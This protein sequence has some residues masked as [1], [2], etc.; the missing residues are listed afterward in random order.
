MAAVASA[1]SA[2]LPFVPVFSIA[3]PATLYLIAQVSRVG[4]CVLATV[5]LLKPHPL[6]PNSLQ[7]E[8]LSHDHN[9]Q[10]CK[11]ADHRLVSRAAGYEFRFWVTTKSSPPLPFSPD[12]DHRLEQHPNSSLYEI[13]FL[14]FKHEHSAGEDDDGAIPVGCSYCCI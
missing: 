12:P 13:C 14:K 3:L 5:Q 1:A 8:L 4:R 2:C 11:C 10:V 9:D 7:K 6:E